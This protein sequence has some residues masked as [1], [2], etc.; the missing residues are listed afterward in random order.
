MKKYIDIETYNNPV[1]RHYRPS[2]TIHDREQL[3][4]R[5]K[6]VMDLLGRWGLVAADIDGED[7]AGR[8]KLKLQEVEEMVHRAVESVELAFE[9][10]KKRGWIVDAP[11]LDEIKNETD[12]PQGE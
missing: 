10:C 7:S 3:S 5:A 6:C 1:D 2:I 4:T 8:S 12:D 11:S 9:E